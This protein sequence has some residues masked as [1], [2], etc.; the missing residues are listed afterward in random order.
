MD[1]NVDA[2]DVNAA[3]AS[4]ASACD[5]A[6]HLLD[7]CH[8]FADGQASLTMLVLKRR[9]TI[10][11]SVK[12]KAAH[13]KLKV[14][15][16]TTSR[17]QIDTLA[18]PYNKA[19]A[20]V[21]RASEDRELAESEIAAMLAPGLIARV[22]ILKST[23]TEYNQGILLKYVPRNAAGRLPALIWISALLSEETEVFEHL[24]PLVKLELKMRLSHRV[25]CE[26]LEA[27]RIRMAKENESWLDRNNAITS[28]IEKDFAR[29]L[30]T[31]NRD[32]SLSSW[33]AFSNRLDMD[34]DFVMAQDDDV[35][36][37]DGDNGDEY[38]NSDQ[39]YDENVNSDSDREDMDSDDPAATDKLDE[40]GHGLVIDSQVSSRIVSK[41]NTPL[42]FHMN[43]NGSAEDIASKKGENNS[44]PVATD[45]GNMEI[46]RDEGRS[47]P[48]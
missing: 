8:A 41:E 34:K 10:V 38:C 26:I 37:S 16:H 39:E 25:E 18:L 29:I 20:A 46:E 11:D 43:E 17:N 33:Q 2:D 4:C 9:Q 48:N 13:S 45:D 47:D 30:A 36:L 31:I 1:I 27:A 3:L 22:R 23:L 6:T 35:H 14:Y 32:R 12:I 24:V 28:F 40:D 42:D 7:M 19:L 5:S 21:R 44:S 15:Q